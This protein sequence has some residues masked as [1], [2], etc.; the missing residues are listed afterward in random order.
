MARVIITRAIIL[1]GAIAAVGEVY[2][3]DKE[4]TNEEVHH[5]DIST[6][7][8][9]VYTNCAEWTDGGKSEQVAEVAG[10]TNE[11]NDDTSSDESVSNSK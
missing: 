6:A 10:E 2:D 1:M 8:E 9:L 5:I 3:T 4:N 7:N 11:A